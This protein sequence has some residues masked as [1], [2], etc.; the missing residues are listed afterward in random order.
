MVELAVARRAQVSKESKEEDLRNSNR[1]REKLKQA[2]IRR[3]ALERRAQQEREKLLSLHLITTSDEL[4]KAVSDIDQLTT[5]TSKKK[6]EKLLLLRN[7]INIWKKVLKRKIAIPFTHSRSQRPVDVIVQE[8]AEYIDANDLPP[9]VTS[10]VSEPTSLI[11]K[12]VEHRFEHEDTHDPEWYHG[13]VVGY[14]PST[15]LFEIAYDGEEDTCNF[16]II[17]DLTL[18]DLV[19]AL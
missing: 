13:S 19:I 18:G 5:S 3:Q 4:F 17:L 10:L 15:K 7:Q 16:D 2:H 14:D 1:R 12:Q 6:Q 8:L 9:I 11:G